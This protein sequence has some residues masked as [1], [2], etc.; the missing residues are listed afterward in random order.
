MVHV[1]GHLPIS[2][3]PELVFDA[4]ADSRN[5]PSYNPDMTGVELLTPGPIGPGSRFH[6]RMGRS[7]MELEIELTEY[8]RPHRLGSRTTSSTMETIGVTTYAPVAGGTEM[9]WDW[10]VRPK[11]WFRLLSPFVG[12][13]GNRM[14]RRI[15]TGLKHRLESTETL[16]P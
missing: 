14:E 16:H 6:A 13:L 12:V 8:D 10:Q 15:W 3:P 11:G 7:G 9:G 2:A 1:S 5:E 4:V